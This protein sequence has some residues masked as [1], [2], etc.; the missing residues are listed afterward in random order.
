MKIAD[1]KQMQQ[2]WRRRG[3]QFIPIKW[4]HC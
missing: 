2:S 4:P 3:A 1:L